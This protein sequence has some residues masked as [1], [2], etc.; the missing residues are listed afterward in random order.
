[1]EILPGKKHDFKWYI[2]DKH[3]LPTT[4]RV[5]LFAEVSL[6]PFTFQRRQ[7]RNNSSCPTRCGFVRPRLYLACHLRN[8]KKKRITF[9]T[10][11]LLTFTCILLT[12]HLYLY[13]NI[14]MYIFFLLFVQVQSN[15]FFNFHFK[16]GIPCGGG[17]QFH[18]SSWIF[19]QMSPV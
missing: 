1:M 3:L 19:A 15:G 13:K 2:T 16:Y 12:P 14:Y 7:K 9:P 10:I 18:R 11:Y 6:I 4:F 17:K 8:F 5:I